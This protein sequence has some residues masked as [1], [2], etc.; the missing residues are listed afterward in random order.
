MIE[1]FIMYGMFWGLLGLF[2]LSP[3]MLYKG[4]YEM[5]YGDLSP[6]DKIVSWIPIYNTYAAEKMYLGGVPWITVSLV[7]TVVSIIVR[8]IVVFLLPISS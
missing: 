3:R 5:C 2:L 7:C 1:R 6:T 8:Y 4:V